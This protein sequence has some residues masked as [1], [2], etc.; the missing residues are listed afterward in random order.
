M[1]LAGVE[2]HGRL[3]S[4]R[5]YDG[6]YRRQGII[7]QAVAV[8]ATALVRPENQESVVKQMRRLGEILFPEDRE[9]RQE[10]EELMQDVLR[11]EGRKSYK[12]RRINLGERGE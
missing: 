9:K 11:R 3:H 7:L 1:A 4:L 5:L 2:T 8:L 10:Q 6:F 12:V